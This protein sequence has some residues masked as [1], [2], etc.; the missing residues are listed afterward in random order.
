LSHPLS[1]AD[2]RTLARVLGRYG[3]GRRGAPQVAASLL[4]AVGRLP[5]TAAEYAWVAA[6]RGRVEPIAP[7]VFI[8]GHWRSGTT[9]L[10]NVMARDPRFGFVTPFATALPWDILTIGR[11]FRPLLRRALPSHRYIDAVAIDEAAP[12]EDEIALANMTPLSYYHALYFPRHFNAIFDDAV[13]FDNLAP[14]EIARWSQ[15][16]RYLYLKLTMD[17]GGRRLLI[18]NPVYTARPALLRAMWPQAKFIHIQRNPYRIFP[19]MRN[20]WVKL[21]AEF[22]LQDYAHVDI[23]AVVFR[24]YARMMDRLVDQTRDMPAGQF[25]EVRF[26]DFQAR[27]I[28]VLGRIYD[29]LD[30]PGFGEARAG[31]EA[32][33]SSIAG[34]KKNAFTLEADTAERIGREW[35]PYIERWGYSRPS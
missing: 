15:R 6:R 4:A 25:I 22:A 29:R 27:P 33:L 12:Q 11:L 31:F 3:F 16:L 23:D 32:Y 9:H 2:L 10:Y 20:F 19:S 17:Q 18:K 8:L 13:F 35:Q 26:E 28:D 5:F 21:F 14:G 30:L 34:Y 7:P 24:T 1:G